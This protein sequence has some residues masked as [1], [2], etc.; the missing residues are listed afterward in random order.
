VP[1]A[2]HS[3]PAGQRTSA[4]PKNISPLQIFGEDVGVEADV[5]VGAGVVASSD[6]L[7]TVFVFAA[8]QPFR[9]VIP[10]HVPV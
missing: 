3:F 10:E 6:V 1:V 5:G 4:L 9:Q 8:T 2:A 7:Q